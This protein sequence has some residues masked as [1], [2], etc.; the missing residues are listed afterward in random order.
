M[1]SRSAVRSRGLSKVVRM[2][3]AVFVCLTFLI[4]PS[5]SW[6]SEIDEYGSCHFTIRD[7]ASAKLWGHGI[8]FLDAVTTMGKIR[9]YQADKDTPYPDTPPRYEN[10]MTSGHYHMEFITGGRDDSDNV[11]M[12]LTHDTNGTPDIIFP[13]AYGG[14]SHNRLML[15]SCFLRS[16]GTRNTDGH[17]TER[18]FGLHNL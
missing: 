14:K 10:Y 11:Q 16:R 8:E 7:V 9:V 13:V 18:C 4:A 17:G 12:I 2:Y 1:A 3:I 6:L 15:L 5:N